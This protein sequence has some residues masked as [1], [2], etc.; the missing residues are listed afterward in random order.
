MDFIT[1]SEPRTTIPR[2][3]VPKEHAEHVTFVAEFRKRWPAHRI[4]AIPNGEYRSPTVAVRLQREGV[5]AGVPDLYIPEWRVWVEMK[6]SKGGRV[7]EE[8]KAWHDYLVHRCNDAVII[9]K[10][11]KD[12]IE[13]C[14]ALFEPNRI[15]EHE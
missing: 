9:A 14:A 3:S 12:G 10:G 6:R 13:Q 15:Y 2:T 7:S 5:S 11:W 8:Q 4:F 1:K